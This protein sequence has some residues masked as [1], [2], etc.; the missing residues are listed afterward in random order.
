[1]VLPDTRGCAALKSKELE[2]VVLGALGSGTHAWNAWLVLLPL[3]LP[4]AW[5][6][7]VQTI[8]RAGG[9]VRRALTGLGGSPGSQCSGSEPPAIGP[10]SRRSAHA[11]SQMNHDSSSTMDC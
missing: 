6:L 3:H 4:K 5:R 11:G 10:G 1:M 2:V 8:S 9:G 7:A